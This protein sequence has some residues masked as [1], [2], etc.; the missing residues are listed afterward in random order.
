MKILEVTIHMTV[1]DDVELYDISLYDHDV[2]DGFE[3][4]RAA[5]RHDRS[6]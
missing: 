1:D 2:C 4:I 6:I 3:L 5:E